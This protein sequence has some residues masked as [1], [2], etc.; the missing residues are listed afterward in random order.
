[1]SWSSWKDLLRAHR[2]SK[3]VVGDVQFLHS[4]LLF[5]ILLAGSVV[6]A[7]KL[8]SVGFFG[9]LRAA[10][11]FDAHCLKISPSGFAQDRLV[12]VDR[13]SVVSRAMSVGSRPVVS[14]KVKVLGSVVGL[15]SRIGAGGQLGGKTSCVG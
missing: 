1:M 13:V 4:S 7:T 11:E 9:L 14:G 15:L 12:E 8:G 2:V 3:P 5:F 6:E 10:A